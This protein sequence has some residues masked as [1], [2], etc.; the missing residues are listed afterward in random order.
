M[1][2]ETAELPSTYAM[3]DFLLELY[4]D[5]AECRPNE[6]R[7]RTLQRLQGI[8]PFDFAVWGGGRAEGRLVTDLT[9]LDQRASVLGEWE[10]VAKQ[11][12]FCDLTLNTL[13]TTARFDDVPDYRKGLA[14]NEH[15]RKFDAS[16]MMATIVAERT[17]GYVSFVGLCSDD[18]PYAFTDNERLLKQMLMPHFAQALRINRKQW[19]AC[20]HV[21]REAIALVSADG[22]VLSAEGPFFDLAE[23]EWGK[24]AM[25]IPNG[26]MQTLKRQE[27]WRGVSV[28]ARITPFGTKHFVHLSAVSALERLSPREREVAEL[29]ASGLSYKYVA[30]ELGSSPSTVRNQVTRIYEKLGLSNKA[31]LASL[32]EREKR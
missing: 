27:Q 4:H 15:W 20:N 24:P 17:D 2:G 31:S 7:L 29:F 10:N 1:L 22:L 13:G 26:V 14:Y 5:A 28:S 18:R 19:D 9:V 11:D 25:R 12:A 6:L 21:E 23:H 30:R 32:I 16:H 3:A 8:V